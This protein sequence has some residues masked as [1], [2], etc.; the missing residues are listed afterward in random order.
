MVVC[1]P[2]QVCNG[3]PDIRPG[4]G[5]P[6]GGEDDVVG[7]GFEHRAGHLRQTF[8]HEASGDVDSTTGNHHRAAGKGPPAVWRAVGVAMDDPDLGYIEGQLIGN[9]LRQRGL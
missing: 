2:R 4:H 8:A 7:V 5:R 1:D 6:T 9:H 3:N